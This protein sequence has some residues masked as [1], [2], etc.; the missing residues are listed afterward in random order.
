[1]DPATLTLLATYGIP[2]I[3]ALAGIILKHFFPKLGN[4]VLPAVKSSSSSPAPIIG[5]QHPLLAKLIGSGIGQSILS[6]LL[7]EAITPAA[8]ASSPAAAPDLYALLA[9]AMAQAQQQQPPAP[10]PAPPVKAA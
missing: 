6:Q 2:I 7:T 3:T 4:G 5:R 8:P 1:M 10:P 9:A